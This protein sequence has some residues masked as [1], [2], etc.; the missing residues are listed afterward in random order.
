MLTFLLTS[1]LFLMPPNPYADA[2]I[3]FHIPRMPG[4]V[5]KPVRIERIFG[6]KKALVI[7]VDF[8]DN[9]YSYA[10]YNFD[11]LIYG[12]SAKSMR[13]YYQEASYGKLLIDQTSLVTDWQRAASTYSYY[14]GDSFGIYSN[15]PR[16]SQGL[17]YEACR[18]ID[19]F[20]NFAQFDENGD[21]VVD[22]VFIVHAGPGAEETGDPRHIWSHKWQLSDN[23]M[24][25]PGPYQT[26]EGVRV[27]HYSTEPEKFNSP[28]SLITV[29]VFVH[30]FGHQI[31]LPDLYDID[32]SSNGMGV[33]CLM[34][35]G[36][37]ARAA[38]SDPPGSSPVHPCAWAKYQLGWSTPVAIERRGLKEIKNAPLPAAATDSTSY[39]MLED[40]KGPDWKE[41]GQGSGEYFLVENRYRAGFDRGLPGNGLLILH[42]DDRKSDN[43]DDD[44]PIVGIM[45]ADGHTS[46]TLSGS[47]RGSEADLWKSSSYGFGDTSRPA[48]YD[49]IGNPTGV[50]VYNISAAES[51]MHADLWVTPVLLG[52]VYSF[53]NPYVKSQTVNKLIITYVPSDSTEFINTYPE[54]KVT[55]FNIAAEKIRTLDVPGSEVDRYTR[56][57]FWD[58]KNDKNQEVTSGMYFYLF[59]S[60]GEKAERNKGRLTI[61][62]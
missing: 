8:P 17:V 2:K 14:V 5:D 57:A 22:N 24:G 38:P 25:C 11:S 34:A 23:S 33:F 29:G 9:A 31:G 27:D 53:P 50:W 18:L 43:R 48:S 12:T 54:F 20:V 49:Y 37:W 15:Y 26:Q 60:L 1:F 7:L 6:T 40:P 35:A 55:I 56:R 21:G 39:R 44:H 42:I 30:E 10:K 59:E 13:N 46:P 47:D 3:G 16:N 62:R 41:S 28:A 52:R 32:Y 61:I 4:M 45:Q 51:L 19:P 36:S 58:L